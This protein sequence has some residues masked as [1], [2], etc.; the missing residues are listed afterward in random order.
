[1][2]AIIGYVKLTF[3]FRQE[4][5]RIVGFCKEL[6]TSGYGKDLEE[7][8]ESLEDL[9]TLHLNALEETGERKRFFKERNITVHKVKPKLDKFSISQHIRKHDV[10]RPHIQPI[11]A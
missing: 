9:V 5:R 4:G 7:A 8:I 1:M 11:R 6:G 3:L 10:M 2:K